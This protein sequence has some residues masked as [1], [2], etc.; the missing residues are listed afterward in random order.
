MFKNLRTKIAGA[1]FAVFLP[2]IAA[3]PPCQYD[4]RHLPLSN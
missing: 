4:L 1:T 2:L 3:A